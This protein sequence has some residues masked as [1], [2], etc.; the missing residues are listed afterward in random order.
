MW[1]RRKK[2]YSMK[3]KEE[4]TRRNE[5]FY[6]KMCVLIWTLY[7]EFIVIWRA[8]GLI[9]YLSMPWQMFSGFLLLPS[10]I[11]LYKLLFPFSV[12][13]LYLCYCLARKKK[14]T[15]HSFVMVRYELQGKNET[16][17]GIRC[18]FGRRNNRSNFEWRINRVRN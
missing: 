5:D 3:N 10:L 6:V 12:I 1:M 2:G 8:I 15:M 16:L 9:K 7:E 11:F 14:R 13:I 4:W 18:F 17:M